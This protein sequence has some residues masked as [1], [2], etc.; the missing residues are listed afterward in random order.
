MKKQI[1]LKKHRLQTQMESLKPGNE[2]FF[3]EYLKEVLESDKP[4]YEK[5]DYIASS[6][7]SIQQKIDYVSSEIKELQTLKKS[8]ESSKQIA[9]ENTASVLGEYGID[10]LEGA[11]ISSITIT[12]TSTKTKEKLIIKDDNAVMGLGFV[13]FSVDEDAI[14]KALQNNTN[15]VKE[16]QEYV[17]VESTTS[18]IASKVKINHK[19]SSNNNNLEEDETTVNKAA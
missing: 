15:E 6:I 5:A 18:T 14:L 1:Q 19:R 17:K 4:Y 16:L 13:K 10:K 8:L 12:P 9:L 3:K 11:V 2:Q 7:E